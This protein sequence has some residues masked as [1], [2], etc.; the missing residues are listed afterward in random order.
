MKKKI[1]LS[2]I[3]ASMLLCSCSTY[4][5]YETNSQDVNVYLLEKAIK[6]ESFESTKMATVSP[7]FIKN[8]IVIR[9]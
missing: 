7:L 1:L 5:K 2:S 9:H 8:E 4:G 6:G 3:I